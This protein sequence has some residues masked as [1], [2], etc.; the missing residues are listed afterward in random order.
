MPTEAI[1][2]LSYDQT[3]IV[4]KCD[5]NSKDLVLQLAGAKWDK[6][7]LVCTLPVSWASAKQLRA[8]FQERLEI[9]DDLY[10]WAVEE[11]QTRVGPCLELRGVTELSDS[12][13]LCKGLYPFQE[14]G[15]KFLIIAQQALLGDPMGAGK[16][17]TAIAAARYIEEQG[18]SGGSL[19]ALI[20]CPASMRKGWQREIETRWPGVPTYVVEGD[21]KKRVARITA[22]DITPGFCIIHWEV[23]RLHS[24]LAPYG[25]MALSEEEKRPKELNKINWKLIIVDEGH[26]L[27]SPTAACTRAV[28]ALGKGL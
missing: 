8:L 22:C 24:R 7:R 13:E 28:W 10:K 1:A 27:A 23:V 6:E 12:S 21:K 4:V 9:G 26:R 20:I 5:F 2:D 3:R 19:P 25:S 16:S 17:F 18:L 11:M 14:A 15:A